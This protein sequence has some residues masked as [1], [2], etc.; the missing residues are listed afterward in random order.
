MKKDYDVQAKET[1]MKE[2]KKAMAMG[3]SV[4][5]WRQYQADENKKKTYVIKIQHHKEHIARLQKE[6]TELEQWLAEH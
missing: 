6:I 4:K 2:E 3:M 1:W 5:E